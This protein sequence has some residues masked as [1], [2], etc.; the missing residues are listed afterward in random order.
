[1]GDGACYRSL[2]QATVKAADDLLLDRLL[3]KARAPL[4][5]RP[6]QYLQAKGP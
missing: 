6:T 2:L 3:D 5:L 4:A 1:M